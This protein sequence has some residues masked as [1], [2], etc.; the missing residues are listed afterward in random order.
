MCAVCVFFKD[1]L[2][3]TFSLVS[4]VVSV[5]CWCLVLTV[6]FFVMAGESSQ[7]K[8]DQLSEEGEGEG[9]EGGHTKSAPV[10]HH[11]RHHHH[12]VP[13]DSSYTCDP[14]DPY[15]CQFCDKAF[16]RLSYLKRHEQ[17]SLAK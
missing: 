1:S 7:E 11:H 8:V 9:E 16:P 13:M 2:T 17:V 12:Q 5:I 15:P 4:P 14:S 3:V 10:H 6:L